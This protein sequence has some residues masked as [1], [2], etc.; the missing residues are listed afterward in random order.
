M[1]AA[2]DLLFE[3]VEKFEYFETELKC[4]FL[5]QVFSPFSRKIPWKTAGILY[6]QA[7]TLN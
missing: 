6:L 7:L 5:V 2:K 4:L 3:F 1:S